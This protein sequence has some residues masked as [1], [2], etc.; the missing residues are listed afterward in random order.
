MPCSMT[1]S[2]YSLTLNL[3]LSK[4]YQTASFEK[5]R[6]RYKS[7]YPR[8]GDPGWDSPDICESM[9]LIPYESYAYVYAFK[10]RPRKSFENVN[11]F[12]E[13]LEILNPLQESQIMD[14]I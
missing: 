11:Y 14:L 1:L 5:V 9:L 6:F 8:A 3:K 12:G 7:T 13:R 10:K 2:F 4:E